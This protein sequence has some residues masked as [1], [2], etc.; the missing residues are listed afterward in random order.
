MFP[1]KRFIAGISP[2]FHSEKKK[3]SIL[4]Q[5]AEKVNDNTLKIYV[6]LEE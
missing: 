2:A 6:I 4:I 1:I 3:I 5:G